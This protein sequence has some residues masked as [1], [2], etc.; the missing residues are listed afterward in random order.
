MKDSKT[1]WATKWLGI[2]QDYLRKNTSFSD[3]SID[4]ITLDKEGNLDMPDYVRYQEYGVKGTNR[5]GT[6]T[7]AVRPDSPYRFKKK[8]IGSNNIKDWA[9][10]KGITSKNAIYLIARSI[11]SK[12]LEAKDELEDALDKTIRSDEAAAEFSIVDDVRSFVIDMIQNSVAAELLRVNTLNVSTIQR[13]MDMGISMNSRQVGARVEWFA[14][15]AQMLLDNSTRFLGGEVVSSSI[16]RRQGGVTRRTGGFT[17][18]SGAAAMSHL[19]TTHIQAGG[20]DAYIKLL[21]RTM[22]LPKM[23]RETLISIKK[24]I[25]NSTSFKEIATGKR[26]RILWQ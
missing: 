9:V 13:L 12:G 2:L 6:G 14:D 3:N 19:L 11:A 1:L 26:V 21:S 10:S 18:V 16:M 25:M 4:Q 20:I 24:S 7:K 23:S 15:R 17:N 5:L 8:S 22:G